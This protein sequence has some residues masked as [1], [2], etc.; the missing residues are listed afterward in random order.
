MRPVQRTRQEERV[1]S[2]SAML[3]D[4][5]KLNVR[6]LWLMLIVAVVLLLVAVAIRT[7]SA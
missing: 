2:R 3:E 4:A 5:M 7:A 6:H 1:G